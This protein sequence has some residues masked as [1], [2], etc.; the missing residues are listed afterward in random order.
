[1]ILLYPFL[2]PSHKITRK[3]KTHTHVRN[4]DTK[5][6][7]RKLVDYHTFP[8]PCKEVECLDCSMAVRR[9]DCSR[10]NSKADSDPYAAV[11]LDRQ[12]LFADRRPTVAAAVAVVTAVVVVVAVR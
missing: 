5:M 1:M 11:R 10:S 6:L 12:V 2:F 7:I 3:K 4:D 8:Y 9:Q